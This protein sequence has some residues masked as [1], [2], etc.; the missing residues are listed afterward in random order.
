MMEFTVEE[1]TISVLECYDGVYSR[2]DN[3]KCVRML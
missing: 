3:N 2:G 1:I